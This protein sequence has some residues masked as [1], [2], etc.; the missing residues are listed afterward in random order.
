MAG[1]TV[2]VGVLSLIRTAI[3]FWFIFYGL[4][5]MTVSEPSPLWI[6][7]VLLAAYGIV[8]LINTILASLKPRKHAV[9]SEGLLTIVVA[10]GIGFL[11]LRSS[12]GG[13]DILILLF[14]CAIL[15]L[16][17]FSLRAIYAEVT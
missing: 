10:V 2:T 11:T 8:S 5:S 1:S 13:R 14:W 6:V 7:M 17:W 16:S 12:S 3:S 4:L 15:S 9:L